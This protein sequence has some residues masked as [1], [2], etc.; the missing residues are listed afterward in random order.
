MPGIQ[1]TVSILYQYYENPLDQ[2]YYNML[3]EDIES[4][5][6]ANPQQRVRFFLL[7][8][9]EEKKNAVALTI[10]E[11]N[12]LEKVLFACSM[13][14]FYEDYSVA[15]GL[16]TEFLQNAADE[17]CH[18]F[19]MTVG[20]GDGLGFCTSAG[21]DDDNSGHVVSSPFLPKRLQIL[22]SLNVVNAADAK[23]VTENLNKR[24]N[25]GFYNRR[26]SEASEEENFGMV[27]I[28]VL[29]TA[30]TR[31]FNNRK[32]DFIYLGNCFVQNAENGYLLKDNALY[33]CASEGSYY[34]QGTDF[35]RL[36]IM[37]NEDNPP[38]D[39][40]SKIA[41]Q[42]CDG[43]NDKLQE[44]RI[45]NSIV[46]SPHNL[47]LAVIN[48]DFSVNNLARYDAIKTATSGIGAILMPP[49]SR[50]V[51]YDVIT[52]VRNDSAKCADV[53]T[54]NPLGIID[55]CNF[56]EKLLAEPALPA[57]TATSLQATLNAL[58]TTND[59]LVI[60][61]R[62]P[63]A[64]T[65]PH[66]NIFPTGFS[67]FFPKAKDNT[68]EFDE[69]VDLFFNEFYIANQ[70]ITPFLHGNA[71]RDFVKDYYTSNEVNLLIRFWRFIRMEIQARLQL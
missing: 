24:V 59:P 9:E 17:D 34:M 2:F 6:E 67:I 58:K 44:P 30:I 27:P 19:L 56:V 66:L 3:V 55:F 61:A 4:F 70:F 5:C 69:Y 11:E 26:I 71:W 18:H 8:Q 36:F 42:I 57:A 53:N 39:V 10:N 65:T 12:K 31:A 48:F 68:F 43:I 38:P 13:D 32:L 7:K 25:R 46:I 63:A 49:E 23:P 29:S 64:G 28:T 54:N 52:A 62:L 41:V 21:L 15:E 35:P 45:V 40:L 16:W 33:L 51:L 1:W 50:Q 47:Q 14:R 37:M 20:H 60:A 22:L